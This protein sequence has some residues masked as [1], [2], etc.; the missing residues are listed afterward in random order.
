MSYLPCLNPNCH[1]HGKPHPNCRCY[2]AGGEFAEGGTVCEMHFPHIPGCEFYAEGGDVDQAH[3]R[4][5][6]S[7]MH[8]VGAPAAH[9]GKSPDRH[10]NNI[11]SGHSGADKAVAGLFESGYGKPPEPDAAANESLDK[12]VSDGS[13]TLPPDAYLGSMQPRQAELLGATRARMATYLGGLKPRPELQPHLSFDEPMDNPDKQ[14]V[15]DSALHVANTPSSV[16]DHIKAGTLE[17]DHI[18]HLNAMYPELSDSYQKKAT[19]EIVKAQMEGRAPDSHV[20]A[21]LGMLVG[22]P[23]SGEVTPASIQAAQAVFA[24]PP[25]GPQQ[26]PGVNAGKKPGGSTK[27]LTNSDKAFLT[28]DQAR[29]ERSQ[30]T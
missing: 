22:S 18:Q 27:A 11:K 19:A 30:K 1:S 6:A 21:G 24:N 7:A 20:R 2:E 14:R 3:A 29:T 12:S 25:G 5:F 4:N 28:D 9:K 15:Y 26:A 10:A 17:P 23:L 13:L 8:A 16:L